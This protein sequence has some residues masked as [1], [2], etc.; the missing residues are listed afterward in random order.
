MYRS[1][2]FKSNPSFSYLS[3]WTYNTKARKVVLSTGSVK[4]LKILTFEL[5]HQAHWVIILE[6]C[7]I[8]LS[9]NGSGWIFIVANCLLSNGTFNEVSLMEHSILS[10]RAHLL[11]MMRDAACKF[12]LSDLILVCILFSRNSNLK[13]AR[14]Q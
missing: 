4:I 7:T 2:V 5:I 3:A 10:L 13:T 1:K 8:L 9:D 12:S 11:W 14:C 6:V